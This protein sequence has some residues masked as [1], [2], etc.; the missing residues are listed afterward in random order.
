M[1]KDHKNDEVTENVKDSNSELNGL[2]CV[3]VADG[4]YTVKQ[5][6]SGRLKALRYGEEWRDCCGDNLIYWLAVELDELRKKITS[7]EPV[8]K[9]I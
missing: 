4:K 6:K 9:N 8:E 1:N 7:T 3:S 2:L 5:D